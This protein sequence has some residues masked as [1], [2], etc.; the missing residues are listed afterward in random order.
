[1]ISTRTN[2]NIANV[3]PLNEIANIKVKINHSD[4]KI[5]Y[6]SKVIL[7]IYYQFENENGS[8]I[9][10]PKSMRWDIEVDED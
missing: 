8:L 1:M 3:V 7:N 9:K 4:Q 10:N 6:Q 5:T 2:S